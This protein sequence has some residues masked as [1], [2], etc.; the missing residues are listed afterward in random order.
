MAAYCLLESYSIFVFD[1]P[2]LWEFKILITEGI[3]ILTLVLEVAALLD[4]ILT[5]NYNM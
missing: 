2:N 1:N 4:L 3:Q 5:Y